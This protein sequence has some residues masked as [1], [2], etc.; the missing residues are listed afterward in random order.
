GA[1]HGLRNAY[2]PCFT[3]IS[4]CGHLPPIVPSWPVPGRGIPKPDTD[5][6]WWLPGTPR[7]GRGGGSAPARHGAGSDVGRGLR[8]LDREPVVVDLASVPSE[9][10]DQ[11]DQEGTCGH[12]GEGGWELARVRRRQNVR[13]D[14]SECALRRLAAFGEPATQLRARDVTLA[15]LRGSIPDVPGASQH[16]THLVQEI[17]GEVEGEG[18][19]RVALG[20]DRDPE[21][22]FVA[23]CADLFGRVTQLP[24]QDRR[25]L[26]AFLAHRPFPGSVVHVLP[27]PGKLRIVSRRRHGRGPPPH[28]DRH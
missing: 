17:A 5:G 11:M 28:R 6:P 27:E 8:A 23:V 26:P 14:P 13:L 1:C 9:V 22:L 7:S 2:R 19:G 25:Q 16:R 24:P 3:R 20:A 21:V 10:P 18:A 4:R 12:S 15:E